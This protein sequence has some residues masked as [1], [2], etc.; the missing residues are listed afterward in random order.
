MNDKVK[1]IPKG[2]IFTVTSGEYSDYYTLTVCK[3][4]KE[5]DTKAMQEEYLSEYPKQKERY[6]MEESQV[7]AWVV[8]EKGYAEEIDFFELHLG[9]YSNADFDLS[10]GGD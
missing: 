10:Q 7:I 5:I 3:A 1:V 2:A 6:C 9:S 4:L 8:N